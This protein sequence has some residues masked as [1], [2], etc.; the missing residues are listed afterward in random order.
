MNARARAHA[1]KSV[2]DWFRALDEQ[3]LRALL[4]R[5]AADTA[6][7]AAAGVDGGVGV[8]IGDASPVVVVV[9]VVVAGVGAD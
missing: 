3:R 8:G 4:Q 2:N 9:V 6:A 1:D 7:A 5:A